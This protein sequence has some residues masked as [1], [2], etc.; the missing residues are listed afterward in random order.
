[1]PDKSRTRSRPRWLPCSGPFS[2]TLRCPGVHLS[3][4][5]SLSLDSRGRLS[6]R[7]RA[8]DM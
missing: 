6:L 3:C 1:M 8:F 7:E 4:H 2:S 5:A